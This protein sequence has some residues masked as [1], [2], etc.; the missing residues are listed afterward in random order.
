MSTSLP[1]R[2]RRLRKMRAGLHQDPL[3]VKS[4]CYFVFF[5][6]TFPII[7]QKPRFLASSSSRART[8]LCEL[9][10]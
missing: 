4:F 8:R 9:N 10:F 6:I 3:T 7:F 5:W 2:E 1:F